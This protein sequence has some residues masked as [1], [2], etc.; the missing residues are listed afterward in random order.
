MM[1]MKPERS[2][3]SDCLLL[4]DHRTCQSSGKQIAVHPNKNLT[5]AAP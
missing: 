4:A 5:R 3:S 2:D 1:A